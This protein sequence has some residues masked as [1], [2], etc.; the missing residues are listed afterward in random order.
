MIT[1]IDTNIISSLWSREES[2]DTLGHKLDG[3]Q[4]DGALIIA[5]PVYAELHAFPGATA[6]FIRDFLHQTRIAVDFEL[7]AT[8]WNAAAAGFALY[9]QR[10][11]ASG[12]GTPKRF[13]TDYL[14]GAHALLR[15]QRLLTLDPAPYHQDFPQLRLL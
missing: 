13:M 14:I 9:A 4:A 7:D 6:A 1:A 10:R 15:A 8:V 5:A 3:A 12:S 2:A 11:R